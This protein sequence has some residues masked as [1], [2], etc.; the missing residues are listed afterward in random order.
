MASQACHFTSIWEMINRESL[1]TLR[2]YVSNSKATCKPTMHASYSVML[3]VQSKF[4][5][6][7]IG[8]C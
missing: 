2:S 3:L 7:E 8:I 5:L 6:I 1:K 4:R